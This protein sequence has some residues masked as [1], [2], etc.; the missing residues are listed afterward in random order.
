MA[1]RLHQVD[2]NSANSKAYEEMAERQ[3]GLEL[4]PEAAARLKVNP[5]WGLTKEELL[6]RAKQAV[7]SGLF[8]EE[9][10]RLIKEGRV[11]SKSRKTKPEG[12]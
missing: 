11:N 12:G 7:E 9:S 3:L 5:I 10:A 8:E 1:Q 4:S 6:K 2:P